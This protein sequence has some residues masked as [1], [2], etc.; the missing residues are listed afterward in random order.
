MNDAVLRAYYSGSN[1]NISL[2]S[3]AGTAVRRN[4]LEN[5]NVPRYGEIFVFHI[6][7]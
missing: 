6:G 1:S 5:T 7:I 3:A 4:V 2:S